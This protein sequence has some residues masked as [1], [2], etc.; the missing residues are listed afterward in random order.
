MGGTSAGAAIASSTMIAS[1]MIANGVEQP[2]FAK[3]MQFL[4]S[5]IIDQPFSQRKRHGRLIK[6]I[7]AHPNRIG[8]GTDESTGLFVNQDRSRV[9]GDGSVFLFKGGSGQDIADES[10]PGYRRLEAG[11]VLDTRVLEL[12]VS[13]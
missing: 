1:T 9:V 2:M 13:R 6:V 12:L 3:G 5:V 8:V 11:D 7:E 10:F 4:P